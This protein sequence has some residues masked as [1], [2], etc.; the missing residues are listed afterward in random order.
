MM[1]FNGYTRCLVVMTACLIFFSLTTDAQLVMKN[2][3]YMHVVEA[4]HTI[5]NNTCVIFM[6]TAENPMQSLGKYF[7][8]ITLLF[9][10]Y[11]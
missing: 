4:V 5:F 2:Q 1:N 9:L 11:T 10:L 7:L 8:I 3:I 6:Y